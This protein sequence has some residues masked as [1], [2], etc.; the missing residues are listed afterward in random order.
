MNISKKKEEELPPEIKNNV[1]AYIN[2]NSSAFDKIRGYLETIIHDAILFRRRFISPNNIDDFKQE[3][4]LEVIQRIHRWIPE[5]GSLKSFLFKC[6]SNR[7]A[8]YFYSS[9]SDRQYIPVEDIEP[10]MDHMSANAFEATDDLNIQ[11]MSRFC[12][13]L[14]IYIIR[15]IAVALYLQLFDRQKDRII[16]DLR[17]MSGRPTR[18]ISFM[19]DYAL[20]TLRRECREAKWQ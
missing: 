13:A 9:G 8:N 12:G 4:W 2:G 11:V 5:R 15:R 1:L 19:V 6:L 3:C 10:Y 7:I 14:E 18:D 16:R 17:E 20:V